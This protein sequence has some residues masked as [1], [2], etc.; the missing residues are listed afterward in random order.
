VAVGEVSVRRNPVGL[1]KL[2]GMASVKKGT[3]RVGG[4]EYLWS[5]HR[6]PTWTSGR[7]SPGHTLLGLAILVESPEP[8]RRQLVLEFGIDP[9]RHGDMPHH[10]RFI[11]PDGRLIEAIQNAIDAGWDPDSRGKRFVYEAGPLQPR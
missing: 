10:Q 11:M 4:A 3:V 9:T 2:T 6:Q 5:V 8:S 1:D 7:S